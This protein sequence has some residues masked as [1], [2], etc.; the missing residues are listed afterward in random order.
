MKLASTKE[1]QSSS[2]HRILINVHCLCWLYS[3]PWGTSELTPLSLFPPTLPGH[4]AGCWFSVVSIA[5]KTII[6][7]ILWPYPCQSF[8]L[9]FSPKIVPCAFFKSSRICS[10][11]STHEFTF[12]LKWI[13][14]W[15][16][17]H[18]PLSIL[19]FLNFCGRWPKPL[20]PWTPTTICFI[21]HILPTF[22][23]RFTFRLAISN[24]YHF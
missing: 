14:G 12:V 7:D 6:P 19:Q 10:I 22:S 3:S 1:S 5:I 15:A 9:P 18:L 23:Q 21:Y 13:S 8:S 2:G 20:D 17:E 16:H 24:N 4:S 11:F